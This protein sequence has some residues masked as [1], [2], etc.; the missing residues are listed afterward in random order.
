MIFAINIRLFAISQKVFKWSAAVAIQVKLRCRRLLLVPAPILSTFAKSKIAPI[1]WQQMPY[2]V[3]H[4]YFRT[5][6]GWRAANSFLGQLEIYI[7]ESQSTS[8]ASH[9]E[10][11]ILNIQFDNDN[12]MF[13][14][15]IIN[16]LFR[17]Q[18]E[19]K[20]NWRFAEETKKRRIQTG[21]QGVGICIL[22]LRWWLI[23]NLD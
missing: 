5:S 8:K 17:F 1:C 4:L 11:F 22:T 20:N 16:R 21:Q 15:A 9:D 2:S 23:S 14:V 10:A 6:K 18:P 12:K 3:E 7:L 19:T 13:A